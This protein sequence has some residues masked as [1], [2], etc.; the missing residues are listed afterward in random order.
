M[1][2]EAHDY[3]FSVSSQYEELLRA[4]RELLGRKNIWVKQ[5]LIQAIML[6]LDKLTHALMELQDSRASDILQQFFA[7]SSM[8]LEGIDDRLHEPYVNHVGFEIYEPLDLVLYGIQHWIDQSRKKIGASIEI[9]HSL[10]FR[11]SIAFQQRVGAF[12]EIMRIR[13]LVNDRVLM[14]ELFDIYRP[15]EEHIRK[16]SHKLTHRNFQGL[17]RPEDAPPGHEQRLARLFAA[18]PIWHYAFHVKRP[19]DVI[20]LHEQVQT[21]AANSPK[22]RVPYANP[23][24]NK[25]DGSLHTKVIS[26]ATPGFARSELEFVT[27]YECLSTE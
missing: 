19:Q 12:T 4:H 7:A 15:L 25:G 27:Q 14:L 11:A 10:R 17:F 1:E 8:N 9:Q 13:L 26:D 6:D 22:F 18:D 20:D 3:I 23:I 24:H 2:S 21:L 5:D 16:G